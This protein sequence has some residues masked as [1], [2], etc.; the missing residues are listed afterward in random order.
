M[1]DNGF[2]EMLMAGIAAREAKTKEETQKSESEQADESRQPPK[3]KNVNEHKTQATR[4][5][6]LDVIAGIFEFMFGIIATVIFAS[7][8]AFFKPAKQLCEKYATEKAEMVIATILAM[9]MWIALLI[10]IC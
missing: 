8:N 5:K 1:E 6:A 9:T 3:E 2:R 10:I 7:I 4:A